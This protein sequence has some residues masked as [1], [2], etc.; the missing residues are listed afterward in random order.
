MAKEYQFSWKCKIPE[1]LLQ[2]D[3]FDRYDDVSLESILSYSFVGDG[4]SWICRVTVKFEDMGFYI[5]WEPKGR[6]AGVLDLVTVFG[7]FSTH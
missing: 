2:G 7:E 5:V 6:D 3:V 4:V 1:Q